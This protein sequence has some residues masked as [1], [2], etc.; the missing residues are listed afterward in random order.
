ML[1]SHRRTDS[2]KLEDSGLTGRTGLFRRQSKKRPDV[3]ADGIP[4]Y[5]ARSFYALFLTSKVNALL[6]CVPLAVVSHYAHGGV[7][8]AGWTFTFS[9]LGIAPL[10][11]RLGFVTEVRASHAQL[12]PAGSTGLAGVPTRPA[13]LPHPWDATSCRKAAPLT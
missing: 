11:E 6:P 12:P 5:L 9:L 7:G 2:S 3:L 8:G 13:G 1:K 10:A 4:T